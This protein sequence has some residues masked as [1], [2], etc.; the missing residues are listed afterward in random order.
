MLRF[1][2]LPAR[3]RTAVSLRAYASSRITSCGLALALTACGS[4]GSKSGPAD[5]AYAPTAP[6]GHCNAVVQQHPIEGATHVPE[7]SVVDYGT[8]PP[9]SG[10][11]YPNWA[12][13]KDYDAAVPEGFW[14]HDLEHGAVVVT[15]NCAIGNDAGACPAEVSAAADMIASLPPDIMCVQLPQQNVS[16]RMVL[17][18]DPK[19]EVRFAASSWGWTLRADCFDRSAFEDFALSHYEQGTEDFCTDGEDPFAAGI[20]TNCGEE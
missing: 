13:Y 8:N 9:S 3:S 5:A 14:V 16:R 10:D 1:G 7:C 2:T 19:L 18:P 20:A 6:A 15:Y 11:H 12:A 17:T 4:S